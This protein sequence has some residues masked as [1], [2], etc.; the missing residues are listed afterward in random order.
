MNKFN[1]SL[2]LHNQNFSFE[3][4]KTIFKKKSISKDN[5]F[6]I[7]NNYKYRKENKFFEDFYE[8]NFSSK[9]NKSFLFNKNIVLNNNI[10]KD[11]D[12]LNYDFLSNEK[13]KEIAK[14]DVNKKFDK[15]ILIKEN[16]SEDVMKYYLN[17]D[18]NPTNYLFKIEFFINNINYFVKNKNTNLLNNIMLKLKKILA[19]NKSFKLYNF[20]TIMKI[21]LNLTTI[22]LMQNDETEIYIDVD[23]N[24]HRE[25]FY[26]CTYVFKKCEEIKP[27]V[28]LTNY[29]GLS[30]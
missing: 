13:I 12:L 10:N 22:K 5:F 2:L 9:E 19:N 4:I 20:E 23:T 14:N 27:K 18:G 6:Y 21:A 30:L 7:R 24:Q 28:D 16:I 25:N 8:T 3:A 11:E 15:R 29:L 26:D 1:I 17:Y